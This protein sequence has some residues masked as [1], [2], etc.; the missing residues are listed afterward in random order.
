MNIRKCKR[1]RPVGRRL[2]VIGFCF[3]GAGRDV[4]DAVPYGRTESSAPTRRDVED[5][6]PYETGRRGHR[7]LQGRTAGAPVPARYRC[8]SG[9]CMSR[10]ICLA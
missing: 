3:W 2:C 7:P 4:E 8:F 6:V 10:A 5:A 9:V 1:R